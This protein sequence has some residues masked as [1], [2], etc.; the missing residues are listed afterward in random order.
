MGSSLDFSVK[1]IYLSIYLAV[2]LSIYLSTYLSIYLSVCL[3]I[4]LSVCL[5]IYLSISIY[6]YISGLF[7]QGISPD[8]ARTMVQSMQILK[9]PLFKK[10]EF[11]HQEMEV[12]GKKWEKMEVFSWD[13]QLERENPYVYCKSLGCFRHRKAYM[14]NYIYT[15]LENW[16]IQIIPE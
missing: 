3:S 9:I 5:S 7:L 12:S 4:Y 8:M 6:I 10:M 13:S 15:R 1:C 2:Y 16:G 11:F 14:Q